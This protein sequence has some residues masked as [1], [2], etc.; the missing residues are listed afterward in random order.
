MHQ[1]LLMY[2]LA[3]F[4]RHSSYSNKDANTYIK[5]YLNISE[6]AELIALIHH[7]QKFLKRGP[8]RCSTREGRVR[9]VSIT[10]HPATHTK[11]TSARVCA[12]ILFKKFTKFLK[13]AIVNTFPCIVL[14]ASNLDFRFKASENL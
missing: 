5:F 11:D 7:F 9:W 10:S 2:Q 8:G 12:N 6:K 14:L 13:R 4:G 1:I 3:K